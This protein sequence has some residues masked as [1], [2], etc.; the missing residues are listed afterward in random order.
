[1]DIFCI[2]LALMVGTAGLPHVIVRFFTVPR[3]RDA[4]TSA[5]YALLFIAV[6]YTTA[7]AV[8][9][10]ARYNLIN[11]VHPGGVG[12]EAGNLRYGA[13]PEWMRRW[14]QTGLLS[15]EDRNGDGRIQ[16]YD[17]ANPVFAP[18]AQAYGWQ[19]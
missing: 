5:G 17:D 4:R 1:T 2:T 12:A 13:R 16:Y 18:T 15:F 7:P 3:V 11:T 8:G 10:M 6:L 9:A 14:E 19:G